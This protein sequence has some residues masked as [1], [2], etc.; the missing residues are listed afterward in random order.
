MTYCIAIPAQLCYGNCRARF[1]HFWVVWSCYWLIHMWLYQRSCETTP[2]V[3]ASL[4]EVASL[5]RIGG[6]SL[7]FTQ[8]RLV[9]SLVNVAGMKLLGCSMP[10]PMPFNLQTIQLIYS[11]RHLRSIVNRK[12]SWGQQKLYIRSVSAPSS[13]WGDKNEN[14]F[15]PIIK[16]L[17]ASYEFHQINWKT[18]PCLIARSNGL[19]LREFWS[20]MLSAFSGL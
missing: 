20:A 2:C 16:C 7:Y 18:T 12:S 14:P 5:L 9:M 4:S 10:F 19:V 15:L 8:L 6:K 3:R 11:V 13:D 1:W 17:L